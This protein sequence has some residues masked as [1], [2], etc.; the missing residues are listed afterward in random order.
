MVLEGKYY[1]IP[2]T[3]YWSKQSGCIDFNPQY[4]PKWSILFIQFI[5]HFRKWSA[6]IH[7]KKLFSKCTYSLIGTSN[8]WIR[9]QLMA[10]INFLFIH[11]SNKV[12]WFIWKNLLTKMFFFKYYVRIQNLKLYLI[13][14]VVDRLL[15][16]GIFFVIAV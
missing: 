9:S 5:P 6:K 14:T 8:H 12:R 16:I 15:L 11:S 13:C 4:K 3:F 2:T 10:K 1:W 7:F